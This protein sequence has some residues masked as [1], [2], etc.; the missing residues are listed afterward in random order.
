MKEGEYENKAQLGDC[1]WASFAEDPL[2]PSPR[3]PGQLTLPRCWHKACTSTFLNYSSCPLGLPP[4]ALLSKL[5][6]HM[7][8]SS[9]LCPLEAAL[10]FLWQR[11]SRITCP[12]LDWSIP[13]LCRCALDVPFLLVGLLT[14]KFRYLF[15]TAPLLHPTSLQQSQSVFQMS[16]WLEPYFLQNILALGM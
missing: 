2:V 16:W 6:P 12:P 11:Q 5:E 4:C 9:S 8:T 14:V 7:L 3:Q 15:T 1:L 10:C 13:T